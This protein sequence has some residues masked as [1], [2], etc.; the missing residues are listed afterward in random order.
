[1]LTPIVRRNKNHW[2]S[3]EFSSEFSK[4]D[5]SILKLQMFD[6]SAIWID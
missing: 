5:L 6:S 4:G 3:I 1:M 2:Y